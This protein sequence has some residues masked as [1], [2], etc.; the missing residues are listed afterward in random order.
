MPTD[1]KTQPAPTE[2]VNANLR[3]LLYLAIGF[4][5]FSTS[6][7]ISK[8]LTAELHTLQIVWLRQLGLMG[9]AIVMLGIHGPGLLRTAFPVLQVTRGTL[10]VLSA[11]CFVVTISYVPLAD[12]VAVTFMAP[13]M[14]TIMGVVF[15]GEQVGIRRWAAVVLGFIGAMIIIRPGMGVFH[16]AIFLVLAAAAFFA[17]RQV[18][19]RALAAS[20]RTQT[21]VIY[22]ALVSVAILTFP[23]PFV[24]R[25]P[26]TGTTY[27]LI[28]AMAALAA[29]GEVMVIRALEI[30]Q[31]S[32]VA[33][34]HYSLIIWATFYGWA[35]FGQLPD[36]WTFVGTSIILATGIYLVNR[37]RIVKRQRERQ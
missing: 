37:E 19:S 11:V 30:A 36:F 22:T 12:A 3:G 7:T 17:M 18:I 23:M 14:V 31:A 16:P 6:D 29:F 4:F 10:A 24:W 27:L 8:F 15:L 28:I 2:P 25:W 35:V 5:T 1:A 26:E 32:V 9:A 13:F 34:M 33:P 20:D 21:T